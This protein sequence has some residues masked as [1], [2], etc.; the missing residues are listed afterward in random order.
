M[1]LFDFECQSCGNRFEYLQLK[2]TE[3]ITCPQCGGG[4]VEKQVSLFNCSGVQLTKRLKLQAAD[5]MRSGE[6]MLRGQRM[7][8]KRIKIA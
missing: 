1:P 3:A 6:K 4:R 5:D 2:P 7:R 8:K